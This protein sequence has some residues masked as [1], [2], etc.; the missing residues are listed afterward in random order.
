MSTVDV[1]AAAVAVAAELRSRADEIES[2]RRLPP[3]LSARLAA[4]GF[5]RMWSPTTVGGLELPPVPG[6]E[7]LE[8]LARADGSAAWCAFIGA[9]SAVVLAYLDPA[10]AREIAREPETLLAGVFAPRGT[11]E[12]CDGGYRVR[13]RWAWGS[14]IHNADWVMGGCQ[15]VV[16]GAVERS[17][18]GAPVP[19]MM[20]VP[21]ADV[22][23][24]D[25]WYAGGLAGTGSTDFAMHDVRVPAGRAVS[26]VVQR[27]V[28][29]P[30][31]AFSPFTFL[32]M[33]I[34][35]V[36][37]GLARAAIDEVVGLA[38]AKHPEGSVRSLAERSAAQAD[39]A[40]AEALLRSAR[41]FFYETVECLWRSAQAMVPIPLA[42]RR[43]VRLATTHAVRA[44]ARAVDLMYDVAGGTSVYRRSPLSRIFRDVHVTTQH[45]M[46]GPGT[47]ELAGRLLFG[48]ETDTTL[49]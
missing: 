38:R 7:A 37:M 40:S 47:L 34:A 33:G 2:L 22:E 28:P 5:Y 41:A 17:V 9:T 23:V 36:A 13:G 45:V 35:A 21:K 4:D 46:V 16:G 18:T 11:A 43:D 44:S 1:H 14:G 19:W 15:R 42:Q 24:L 27:P 10:V 25:T 6:L 29:R 12:A 30:L 49:L 8:V 32:A 31:Y 20:I 48:L 39:V 26:L 3:D